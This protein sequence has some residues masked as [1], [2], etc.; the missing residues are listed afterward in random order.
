MTNIRYVHDPTVPFQPL[1]LNYCFISYCEYFRSTR[2]YPDFEEV[3]MNVI[4]LFK[5]CIW[6]REGVVE[7]LQETQTEKIGPVDQF[8]LLCLFATDI[9]ILIL[10][11]WTWKV[12][13]VLE[14]VYIIYK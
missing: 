9:F 12:Y 10:R 1:F 13:I 2:I 8:V 6:E 5:K 11:K 4:Q 3:V 14:S 7:A